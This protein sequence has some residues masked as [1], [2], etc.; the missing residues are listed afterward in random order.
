MPVPSYNATLKQVITAMCTY[1]LTELAAYGIDATRI[2]DKMPEQLQGLYP[3]I[4][5]WTSRQ[6]GEWPMDD[7]GAV[8]MK[9]IGTT[10][11]TQG[12]EIHHVQCVVIVGPRDGNASDIEYACRDWP[13]RIRAC[14]M[15]H[16]Q[17]GGIVSLIE[18]QDYAIIPVPL[19]SGN[20]IGV[21]HTCEITSRPI[22]TTNQ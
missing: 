4:V 20:Y 6:G 14:F 9:T 13:R 15:A 2:Y 8:T 21:S 12:T 19:G 17:L 10:P 16:H 3:S 18:V 5:H 7:K 11:T 22:F 1:E